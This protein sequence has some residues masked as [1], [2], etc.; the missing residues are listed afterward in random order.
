MG[1]YV[2]SVLFISF[3]FSHRS[4]SLDLYIYCFGLHCCSD[5]GGLDSDDVPDVVLSQKEYQKQAA[6]SS[7]PVQDTSLS[8]ATFDI[9]RIHYHYPVVF[10][11]HSVDSIHVCLK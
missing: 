4:G 5:S 2:N 11:F 7:C 8:I 9:N 10:I 3:L 1:M 6:S